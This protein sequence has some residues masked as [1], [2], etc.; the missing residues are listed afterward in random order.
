MIRYC[1]AL[2]CVVLLAA[3]TSPREPLRIGISPWPGYEFIYLAEH[4]GYFRDAG[5]ELTILDFQS[6][7]DTRYALTENRIDIG[8]L[9]TGELILS[10][11]R[12]PALR[13]FY[14]INYS[15]GADVIVARGGIT[16]PADLAGKTVGIEPGTF[17]IAL[18]SAA[19]QQ[20]ELAI[21]D[22]KLLNTPKERSLEALQSGIIDA[23]V[24]FSPH[25]EELLNLPDTRIIFSSAQAPEMIVDLL[26]ARQTILTSRR[27]E[28]QKMLAAI[29][30]AKQ[31]AR[32]HPATAHAF[33]ATHLGISRA[34]LQKSLALIR[35]PDAAQQRAVLAADGSLARAISALQSDMRQLQ[36]IASDAPAA[37]YISA[38]VVE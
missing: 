17:D 10:R 24:S 26:A 22:V 9:T 32:D 1:I 15:H 7:S 34:D 38:R 18:L 16:T 20:T 14:V 25:L 27:A 28:L 2:L 8:A 5:L 3:C 11:E 29:E 33:M 36:L 30:A 13:A 19:L 4:L 37:R 23:S 12:E 35:F 21:A 31:F 6:L